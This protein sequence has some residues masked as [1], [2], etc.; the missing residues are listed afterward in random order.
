MTAPAHHTNLKKKATKLEMNAKAKK[1]RGWPYLKFNCDEGGAEHVAA[2]HCFVKF[3][4]VQVPQQHL[5][6]HPSLQEI[7][8][9]STSSSFISVWFDDHDDFGDSAAQQAN[10][11]KT[12][13]AKSGLPPE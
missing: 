5:A 13:S 12:K 2:L 9:Q 1:K 4:H 6:H 7:L 3:I 10:N 11:A 8:L